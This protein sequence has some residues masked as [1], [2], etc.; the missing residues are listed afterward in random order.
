MYE[1]DKT[2][3]KEIRLAAKINQHEAGKRVGRTSKDVSHYETGRAKPTGDVVLNY[4]IA[5]EKSPL[6]IAKEV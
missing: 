1:V 3:L 2:K 5:F 6:E 4:L